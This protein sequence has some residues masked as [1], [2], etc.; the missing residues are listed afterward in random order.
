MA[1]D[2]KMRG[3]TLPTTYIWDVSPI[4]DLNLSN[5]VKE[6]LVRMY[7]NINSIA[8]VTNTKESGYYLT[9]ALYYNDQQWFPNTNTGELTNPYIKPVN[10]SGGRV[11]LKDIALPNTGTV[12][13]PHN[14]PCTPQTRIFVKYADA[15]NS[16]GTSFLPL[17]Y[18][19][20][21]LANVIE[22]NAD[23]VNVNITTNSNRTDY[24]AIVVLD[25]IQN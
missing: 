3:T 1:F 25:F 17:P 14:I 12:S 22:L 20:A 23:N 18:A 4:Y 6:L 16:A 2:T 5:D 7:Q 10:R 19:S 15:V 9:D 24:T 21:T 13:I 8:L 11:T